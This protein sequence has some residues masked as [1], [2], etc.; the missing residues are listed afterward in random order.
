MKGRSILE[1]VIKKK[2]ICDTTYLINT[3]ICNR[4]EGWIL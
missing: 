3:Y 1:Y 4:K 2:P